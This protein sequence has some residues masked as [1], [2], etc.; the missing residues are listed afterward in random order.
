MIRRWGQD[1]TGHIPPA[2]GHEPRIDEL[3]KPRHL[4]IDEAVLAEHMRDRP[5]GRRGR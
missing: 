4:P 3:G 2:L 1:L 5:S